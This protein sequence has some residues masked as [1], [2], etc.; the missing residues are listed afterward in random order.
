MGGVAA[1]ITLPVVLLEVASVGRRLVLPDRHQIAIGADGIHLFA[2]RDQIVGFHAIVLHPA[3]TW[4]WS[5]YVFLV[6]DPRTREGVVE[7]RDLVM[8]DFRIGL[9]AVDPFLEDGLIIEVERQT[10][11]VE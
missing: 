11:S 1:P 10:G 7:H 3:R 5:A 2:D 8:K 6:D 4:I 9:V